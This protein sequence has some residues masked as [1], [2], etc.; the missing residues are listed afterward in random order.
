[1]KGLHLSPAY[2]HIWPLSLR[3]AGQYPNTII[4][5]I[6]VAWMQQLDEACNGNEEVSALY[7]KTKAQRQFIISR[8]LE[9]QQLTHPKTK[10]ILHWQPP[11]IVILR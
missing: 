8:M 11:A 7:M 5:N 6:P 9:K 4:E 2:Y 3:I 10:A 1:V